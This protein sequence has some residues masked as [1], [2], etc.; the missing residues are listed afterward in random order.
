MKKA[1]NTALL[2]IGAIGVII[3]VAIA[4]IAYSRS[5]KIS[6]AT[7]P[8]T[9][10]KAPGAAANTPSNPTSTASDKV[11]DLL[12]GRQTAELTKQQKARNT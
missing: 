11:L 9:A 4:Y 3:I 6:I 2:T 10:A 12:K 5:N 7:A 1:S 8:G